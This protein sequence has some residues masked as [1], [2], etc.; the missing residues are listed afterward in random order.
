MASA[1]K[2]LATYQDVLAAPA[3]QVAQLVHGE[4]VLQP[5]PALPHALAG[6][7]LTSELDG[8]FGDRRG[9]RG[10][11][12]WVI[13]FEPELHLGAD[14][15]VPDIAGW[16]RERMPVM[17][18]APYAELAPD[19]CCEIL[20]ASTARFDRGSKLP[21]Y[22][23]HGVGY[24]WLVDPMHQ[25]LEVLALDGDSYRLVATYGGDDVIAAPPFEAAE[26]DLAA[27]WSR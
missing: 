18:A 12:G 1:A 5:R 19:F 17:P 27:L 25:T 26:I 20:S 22:A 9:S 7:R 15:L 11:G 13:L 4:L 8:R 6:T 23:A 10:P 14:V 16:R 2:K 24:I 21:I 3:H